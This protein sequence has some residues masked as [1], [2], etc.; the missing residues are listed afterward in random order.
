MSMMFE[1]LANYIRSRIEVSDEQLKEIEQLCTVHHG[2]KG[3]VLLKSG[4]VC[5]NTFFV[6]KVA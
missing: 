1:V 6:V 2:K 4:E 5:K 3:D